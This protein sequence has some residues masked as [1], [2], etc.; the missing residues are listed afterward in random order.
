MQSFGSRNLSLRYGAGVQEAKLPQEWIALV[1][2]IAPPSQERT[3]H[4]AVQRALDNPVAAPPLHA[5]VHSRNI[6]IIVPDKTRRAGTALVLPFLLNE[7][8]AAGI[9]DE[10]IT[11][12][13]ATGTHPA[14]SLAEQQELIGPGMHERFRVLE[15]DSRDEG[16][17][18]LV[19]TTRF[20][21]RVLLNRVVA[22]ADFIVVAGTIVHHYFAGFGGG[23][24]MIL[25][26]VAAYSTAVTNHRRT[27]TDVGRFHTA[28]RDGNIE[29]NPVME[30]ILAAVR[31]FPPCWY[32]AA[33]LDER[34]DIAEAVS[35]DLIEAHRAGCAI[36][37]RM[38]SESLERKAHVCVAGA[39]GFPKDINFIQ[40]HKAM[41]HAHYALE[42]D[43]VLICVAECGE[44]IGNNTFLD[45]FRYPDGAS[46]NEAL[47]T[48]YAMNA[49][50]ALAVREKAA[51]FRIILVSSLDPD[52]VRLMGIEPA[53]SLQAAIDR[54]REYQPGPQAVV[55]LPNASLTVP[56]VG[57]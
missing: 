14:Q 49:H 45:W 43:G 31:F 56:V 55:I 17:C 25:P 52:S 9:R 16:E 11:I 32:F 19:G 36:V 34:G 27:I 46:F 7:L 12:M 42:D 26:G 23:A 24:K 18:T 40:S 53:I 10:W 20:G 2:G 35:G 28:C 15:H 13:F 50:T 29:G 54:A 41:H 57:R 38:Y 3:G 21:T 8:H 4:A 47:L 5:A 6:V 37:D 48:R 44:G 22:E 33:I 30:D 1:P 39:G 51:R